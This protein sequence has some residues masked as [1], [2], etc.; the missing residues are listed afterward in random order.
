MES[1]ALLNASTPEVVDMPIFTIEPIILVPSFLSLLASLIVIIFNCFSPLNM[2]A[3]RKMVFGV[4][5][6]DILFYIPK[7]TAGFPYTKSGLFCDIVEAIALFGGIS[8]FFWAASFA[9]ALYKVVKHENSQVVEQAFKHYFLFSVG[10]PILFAIGVSLIDFVKYD[11]D[12]FS[13]VHPTYVGEVDYSFIFFADV[14]LV[15]ASGLSIIWYIMASVHIRKYLAKAGK[16][17]VV[18]LLLYPAIMLVCWIPVRTAHILTLCGFAP[19]Q[20]LVVKL[21]AWGHLQGLFDALVYGG[22][23]S[24]IKVLCNF[25]NCCKKS[26]AAK[27]KAQEMKRTASKM[28]KASDDSEE[29]ESLQQT[30]KRRLLAP[31]SAKSSESIGRSQLHSTPH[32]FATVN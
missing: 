9:S 1:F 20:S 7:V 2:D 6:G 21:Q 17:E 32:I 4:F 11:P 14:P 27:S 13:C 19:S 15:I 28:S 22:S 24:A 10:L 31:N 25:R 26:E 5:I 23:K 29:V 12:T 18:T 3:F 8:S 16:S 30:L